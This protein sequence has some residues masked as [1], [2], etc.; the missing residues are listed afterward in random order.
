VPSDVSTFD[1]VVT[2][3]VEIAGHPATNMLWLGFA[4]ETGPGR[5]VTDC[6]AGPLDDSLAERGV[7][8]R[9]ARACRIAVALSTSEPC[10]Q[11]KRATSA[12]HL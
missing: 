3:A 5:A 6:R 8:K 4:H 10:G 11:P 9:G 7:D 12:N 1:L 2:H